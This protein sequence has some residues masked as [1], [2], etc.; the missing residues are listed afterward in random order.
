MHDEENVSTKPACAQT[1]PRI[2]LPHGDQERAQ[3][4][5]PSAC[6]GA[7]APVGLTGDASMFER[8]KTRREF[9]AAAMGRKAAR[10][11]FVLQ[12]LRR[13]DDDPPRF[14]FT[15]SKRTSKSAAERNRIRRRLR[16]AV[17]LT[18][19]AHAHRGHDYVLIGR[20]GSLKEGFA[21][22]QAA[23]ASALKQASTTA[24]PRSA[25]RARQT[26]EE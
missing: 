12:A 11:A 21:N 26:D 13:A 15:V 4:A 19:E 7:Q 25:P 2:S 16:E 5:R 1:P 18:A 24:K 17:R 10:P 9:L 22:L 14:G 20:H 3:G 6:E 23:L 8:L